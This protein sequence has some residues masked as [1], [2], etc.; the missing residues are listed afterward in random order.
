[1]HASTEELTLLDLVPFG[2]A[3]AKG[4]YFAMRLSCPRNEGWQGWRP[5]QFVMLRPES[6]AQELTWGRPFGICQI[7]ERNLVCFF[8]VCGRGTERLSRLRR[9]ELVRV[10]GPLGNG[11]AIEPKK[12]TLLLAGGMGIAPFVGYVHHHPHP[13]NL[14]MLF[15]HRD[16]VS[17]YPV[18]SINERIPLDSL[19][20]DKPGDLDNFIFTIEERIRE[21]AEQDGLVLAC[22]PLPFLRTVKR[23]AAE[24]GARAQLSLENRMACGVGACLGCVAKTTEAWPVPASRGVRVQVCTHGPVFWSEQIDLDSN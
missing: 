12:A 1:M 3:G 2:P 22:G 6:F 23:F 17:C 19:R 21:Y 18:D 20:E 16:P 5:G 14:T 24:F 4:R 11:F 8:Q 10:W 7:N 15:G 9:G 13:W